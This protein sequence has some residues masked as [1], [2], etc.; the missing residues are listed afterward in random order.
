MPYAMGKCHC[1]YHFEI[2]KAGRIVL[3]K[4]VWDEFQLSPG[5]SWR[6]RVSR[7][8]EPQGWD[9]SGQWATLQQPT[10]AA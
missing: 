7:N 6:W 8:C 3:P 2:D 9:R 1:G 4:P 10:T 5:D